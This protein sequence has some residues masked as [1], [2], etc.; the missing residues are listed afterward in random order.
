[1]LNRFHPVY[2]A[3][4]SL[5]GS[6]IDIE[7]VL[8]PHLDE[9]LEELID[10]LS[11][12]P[13]FFERL[14]PVSTTVGNTK[15][16]GRNWAEMTIRCYREFGRILTRVTVFLKQALENNYGEPTMVPFM[17]LAVDPDTLTRL[18]E[19]D[20]ETGEN[21]YGKLIE[22]F[23]NGVVAPAV[24]TPFH[25]ILPLL[26]RPFDRQLCI[27]LG[28][29][30]YAPILRAY[31]RYLK[32]IGENRM[33]VA[34][35]A[36][37]A[38]MTPETIKTLR[39]EFA[40]FCAERKFTK[41]HL[42]LLLDATDAPKVP[43]DKL[44]KTW[45]AAKMPGLDDG[46]ISLVFRDPVFSNWMMTSHPSIKKI[47]DRTIAKV[48]GGLSA[49]NID[50]TWSHFESLE[51]LTQSPKGAVNLE[52]RIL[53][54]CELGYLA[55]SP[56]TFVRRKLIKRFGSGK[57]EPMGVKIEARPPQADPLGEQSR[58]GKWRGWAIDGAKTPRVM[59]NASYV[60]RLSR[61]S[62][63][64]VVSPGW[65]VGWNLT[66][67]A[68][69]E[70]LGGKPATMTG[71]ILGLLAKLTGVKAKAAVERNVGAF[72]LRYALI[73][74]R[75]HFI[76][77]ELGEADI[78]LD[79]MVNDILRKGCRRK[80]KPNEIA[81]AG[82]AAQAYF[83]LLDSGN[84]CALA[85][86][87]MDQRGMFQT[88]MML[89]LAFCN[90]VAAHK[91]LG[92]TKA[93]NETVRVLQ[94]ELL[95][96]S[97]A[98]RRYDLASYGVSQTAWKKALAPEVSDSDLNVVERAARRTA[99]RHLTPFGHRDLFSADDEEISTN[100]GHHWSAEIAIPNYQW[101]NP[102]FCGVRE[103]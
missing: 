27:R 3:Y 73:Y 2:H 96:F 86:E 55:V 19:H 103:A 62:Q 52:Q 39:E 69:V 18:I 6:R 57:H 98:Y 38:M 85:S 56:D 17:S 15:V 71:G 88:A 35:W 66:R 93:A 49:Q 97:S 7:R 9:D 81:A 46:D 44:M 4:T 102:Y 60:R 16:K 58:F 70:F 32:K 26:S 99:A 29:T 74:W 68:C 25:N 11:E 36:P 31:E 72:L 76:Q 78:R 34:F 87:N 13:Q 43:L 61:G 59:P 47:I 30:F 48:D 101:A 94:R 89:T 23:E 79:E 65:K 53:K 51:A 12:P 41:P 82:T 14:S 95:D 77:H 42:V 45:C 100:V 37:E 40:R 33:V 54:L 5:A 91:Y 21:S 83:F 10:Q 22:L 67:E 8:Q 75:E 92:E 84:S 24:T 1:M 20:Y 80:A 64:C 63:K 50:Y 90:A 28:L